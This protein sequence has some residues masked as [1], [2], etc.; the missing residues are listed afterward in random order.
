MP[1]RPASPKK[2]GGKP[3]QLTRLRPSQ[4]GRPTRNPNLNPHPPRASPTPSR[5]RQE[6]GASP[7]PRSSRAP[8]ARPARRLLRACRP[9]PGRR[10]RATA[11]SPPPPFSL[12][13]R[14]S[15][16]SPRPP[17]ALARPPR[18]QAAGPP[19]PVRHLLVKLAPASPTSLPPPV[20]CRP[21]QCPVVPPPQLA[22]APSPALDFPYA[23]PKHGRPSSHG[24][25]ELPRPPAYPLLL[26][27]AAIAASTRRPTSSV[28][29]TPTVVLHGSCRPPSS[30]WAFLL[31]PRCRFPPS[32]STAA[33]VSAPPCPACTPS[34]E[35][36]T[37]PAR[38]TPC[39]CF[40]PMTSCAPLQ[41]TP[42]RCLLKFLQ[43]TWR[44][45][46][47]VVYLV[48]VWFRVGHLLMLPLIRDV[49]GSARD[50]D[51]V[52][53]HPVAVNLEEWNRH[54]HHQP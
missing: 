38:A 49:T 50:Q 13:R 40:G 1:N 28:P 29:A 19:L 53:T 12:L 9:S 27:V 26:L 42:T 39:P 30:S 7:L 35:P 18:P 41:P 44:P 45:P 33:A 2:G 22:A 17:P 21:R 52:K 11:P 54:I 4:P 46:T 24:W 14:P 43:E 5:R 20:L 15:P 37:R 6:E 48:L 34:S 10:P 25:Q 8:R 31:D 47:V 32:T 3:A 16:A 51:I 23:A 36:P